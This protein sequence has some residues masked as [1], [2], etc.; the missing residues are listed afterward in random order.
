ML[1]RVHGP[2]S[3][4]FESYFIECLEELNKIAM[5]FVQKQD[6]ESG[7]QILNLC[8][9]LTTPGRYGNYPIQRNQ[10]YNNLGCIFRRA[11]KMKAAFKYLQSALSILSNSNLMKHSA[12]T[13]L[14][15]CAVLSQLGE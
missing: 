4:E 3:K 15:L 10:T 14:N 5:K 13:Y 1:S 2:P 8:D 12:M 6:I 9:E 7:T 11:G